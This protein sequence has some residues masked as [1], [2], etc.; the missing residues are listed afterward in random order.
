MYRTIENAASKEPVRVDLSGKVIVVTSCF[1]DHVWFECYSEI[2]MFTTYFH[3]L[4][5]RKHEFRIRF[6]LII[7]PLYSGELG[8]FIWFLLDCVR[9]N[10]SYPLFPGS[11]IFCGSCSEW[12][13]IPFACT[14]F[15]WLQEEENSCKTEAF[16]MKK[17]RCY[18]L[19]T[20]YSYPL[21]IN[22]P[23]SIK[24]FNLPARSLLNSIIFLDNLN[25]IEKH[26]MIQNDGG[27]CFVSNEWKTTD[28]NIWKVAVDC[29]FGIFQSLL[30]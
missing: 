4:R 28:C 8:H 10:W 1:R 21:L 7:L 17:M 20:R 5:D 23:S 6:L 14:K 15:F 12:Q 30:R 13:T 29:L 3:C 19:P 18:N 27:E 24:T 25:A 11:L 22:L 2:Y 26:P 16:L 9:K